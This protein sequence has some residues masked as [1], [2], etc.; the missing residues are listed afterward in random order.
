MNYD[1]VAALEKLSV[2]V[3]EIFGEED[4]LVPVQKSVEIMKQAFE[5][6]G[7]KDVTFRVFPGADHSIQVSSRRG[8]R[9]LAPGY[10]ETMIGWLEKRLDLR[11][12]EGRKLRPVAS[13]L[14]NNRPGR[15]GS[16]IPD[17]GN[18]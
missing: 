14:K 2:P 3:L 13:N 1:P 6:S 9:Q 4:E 18:P 12:A 5:R 15:E 10:V 11:A 17:S 16:S 8:D 7:N